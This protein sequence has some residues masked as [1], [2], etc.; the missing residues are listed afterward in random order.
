[1]DEKS[2]GADWKPW[3]VNGNDGSCEGMMHT[4]GRHL[5]VQF[6]PEARPGP[7]DTAFVFDRFVSLL[8]A[9]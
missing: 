8:D 6:H 4:G 7:T 2:L 3:F 5:A 9:P 1:M